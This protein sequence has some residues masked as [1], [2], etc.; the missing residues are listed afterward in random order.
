VFFDVNQNVRGKSLAAPFSPRRHRDA[1][2]SMPLRWSELG[3]VYPTDFTVL[4]APERLGALGDPWA[5]ILDA[6]TDLEAALGPV[7]HA[8]TA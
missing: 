8:A 6:K 1:T 4:T 2:V 3:E 7:A 5:G